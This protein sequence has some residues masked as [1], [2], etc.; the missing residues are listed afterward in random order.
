M[1]RR[2]WAILGIALVILVAGGWYLVSLQ[3]EAIM[4]G[5]APTLRNDGMPPYESGFDG[6]RVAGVQP[7]AA[8]C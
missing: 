5:P 1:T 4:S 2:S 8:V 6:T 3:I 7:V